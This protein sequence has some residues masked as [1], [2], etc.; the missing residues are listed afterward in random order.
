MEMRQLTMDGTLK[1]V[2]PSNEIIERVNTTY[3]KTG[4]F[5]HYRYYY[6]ILWTEPLSRHPIQAGYGDETA[7]NGRDAQIRLTE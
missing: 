7:D 4:V 2:S 3:S 5:T 1:Y 6:T